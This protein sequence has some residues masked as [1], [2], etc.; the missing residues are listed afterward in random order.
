MNHEYGLPELS[1]IVVR[2]QQRPVPKTLGVASDATA[3]SP[4]VVAGAAA[5]AGDHHGGLADGP[6]AAASSAVV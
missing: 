1:A 2:Q 4:S 3:N 6:N 5:S